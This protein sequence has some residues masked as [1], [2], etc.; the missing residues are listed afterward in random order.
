MQKPFALF[1]MKRN[2]AQT[3]RNKAARLETEGAEA[4]DWDPAISRTESA[5][6]GNT[7]V[8]EPFAVFRLPASP[9]GKTTRKPEKPQASVALKYRQRL[10]DISLKYEKL[11]SAVNLFGVG[12]AESKHA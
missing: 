11:M 1:R 6:L 10:S 5:Q 2:D 7:A 4:F 8:F 3:T 12:N 9:Q